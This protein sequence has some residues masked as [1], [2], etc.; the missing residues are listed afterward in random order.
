MPIRKQALV[1][2]FLLLLFVVAA[3]G[4]NLFNFGASVEKDA[5]FNR[6][7]S[8]Q[9][10]IGETRKKK[11][12]KFVVNFLIALFIIKSVLVPIALKVMA[13]LSSV[14]VVLSVMSL[15]VSS[16]AGYSKVAWQHAAPNIK[17]IQ[18]ADPWSKDESILNSGNGGLDY[19]GDTNDIGY[20]YDI[21]TGSLQHYHYYNK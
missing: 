17:F 8:D 18:A 13:V 15:I 10:P 2:V 6:T 19:L 12:G 11:K 16:L 4:F 5:I 14:S 1:F 9:G 3:S 20:G 21:G 7:S